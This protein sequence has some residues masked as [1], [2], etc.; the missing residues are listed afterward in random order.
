M[1]RQM[2]PRRNARGVASSRRLEILDAAAE[3]LAEKGILVATVRDIGDRAGILS[4]SLYHHFSS[5]EEMITEILVPVIQSQISAFDA[6]VAETDDAR[7]IVRRLIGAAVEQTAVNPHA[8][9]ILRN[10]SHHIGE[11]PGLEAVVREQG[12]VMS[13]WV[14]AV[15]DGIDSRRFRADVDPQIATMSIADVV[16]GAYRFMKPVGRS[17]AA[18]V[19]DQLTALI[20]D[21]LGAK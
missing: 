10:D 9:R 13:R 7:E 15:K 17:S 1:S 14:S 21:G 11:M 12:A 8:A 5:K 3:V 6:I 2:V 19:T 20:L 4:G 16:L 18:S